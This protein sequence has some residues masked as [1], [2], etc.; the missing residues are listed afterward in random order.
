MTEEKRKQNTRFMLIYMSII[1]GIIGA[2]LGAYT[3]GLMTAKATDFGTG[4]RLTVSEISALQ[5]MPPL[6]LGTAAGAVI[7]GLFFGGLVYFALKVDND[8]NYTYK[9]DEI[10]GTGG[11]MTEKDF[12]EYEKKYIEPE[13]KD[14][15]QPSPNMILGNRMKRPNDS[16][17][18]IGNN[19]IAVVG[20]AGSGKSRFIIKPNLLT[21]NS[22]FVI[23]DPSG[24]IINSLGKV[25]VE[26][27]YKIKVFNI[28]D[29]RHSNCYNPLEYIRNSEGVRMVIDCLI[30]NTTDKNSKGGEQ[31]WVDTE[32]LLY[33]ACIFYLLEHCHDK[34]KRNFASVTNMINMS[35][36]NEND[37]Y[38]KSPLDKIFESVPKS[39]LAWQYYKGF[40]QG[41]GKTMKSIIISCIARLQPFLTPQV[42]SLTKMDEMELGKL[43][44]EKTA[45][46][47]IVPQADHT[48][49]FLPSML[50]SQLF[51]TLYYK[52]EQQKAAGGSEALRVPVRCLMDEFANIGTIPAFPSKLSTMRKYNISATIMLQDISQLEAM[53]EDEWRTIMGNCSTYIFLGTQEPNTLKYFSEMLGKMTITSRSRS[54]N[55]GGKSGGGSGRNFQQTA[56]EVMM[57]DE[58]ARMDAKKE[59]VFVQNQ[60]PMLDDKYKYENHPLYKLTG[61]GDPG[62]MFLYNQMPAYDNTRPLNINSLLRAR[63]EAARVT[64]KNDVT[65]PEKAE[66][67]KLRSGIE[68]AY[69]QMVI[70]KKADAK[71]FDFALNMGI[72]EAMSEP[73]AAACIVL[74]GIQ[75]K[76]LPELASQISQITQKCPL[77]VFSDLGTD[78][79]VG[80]A[81]T[82]PDGLGALQDDRLVAFDRLSDD[83]NIYML[84]IRSRAY[85][86]YKYA[87]MASV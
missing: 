80:A 49:D 54:W 20:G 24:E 16:R 58:M 63:A 3:G 72:R 33:S 82:G 13:P 39:S 46:F 59:I 71:A 19:N 25:L 45:L 60:R 31:F 86:E 57:G 68:E 77:A 62:Q 67:T 76:R 6:N 37:P 61:D 64:S 23:T 4:I 14:P 8:R 28:S 70:E 26:H 2:Y 41:A 15:H 38:A 83:S 43:G 18:M 50:Y 17:K 48:Y 47:I 10:A 40:K 56:R 75:T 87:V 84:A 32:R 81:V 34:S 21:M 11:F 5:L 44:E 27:G 85:S 69:N 30:N 74:K 55:K 12:Q 9:L 79:M 35:M 66:D 51:E 1:T 65:D 36:V 22:S 52:G 42:I 78:N 53:Y 73:G 7:G 29:M